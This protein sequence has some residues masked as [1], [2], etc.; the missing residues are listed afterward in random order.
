MI[1]LYISFIYITFLSVGPII[2]RRLGLIN[3][4]S[5]KLLRSKDKKT[6]NENDG[7][8]SSLDTVAKND[9]SSNS[10]LQNP[11]IPIN[12]ALLEKKVTTVESVNN[13]D[14]LKQL[15]TNKKPIKPIS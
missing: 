2:K 1:L 6:E 9:H 3:E 4:S 7:S 10:N 12:S 14:H 5:E 13:G 15:L 11:E 8:S